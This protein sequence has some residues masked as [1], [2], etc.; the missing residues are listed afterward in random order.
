MVRIRTIVLAMLAVLALPASAADSWFG[1]ELCT[2]GNVVQK[3]GT[4]YYCFST[5]VD[6]DVL[7][8]N[9]HNFTVY[10]N[11][12]H[13][14]TLTGAQ[15]TVWRCDSHP[16]DETHAERQKVCTPWYIDFT[17]DGVPDATPL[18]ATVGKTGWD[19][20]YVGAQLIFIQVNAITA[21]NIARVRVDSHK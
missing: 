9:N 11:P 7:T 14:G 16:T 21:G 19:T 20:P 3:G 15:V 1:N 10:L 5:A 13:D 18:D 8:L 17:G 4:A 2:A 12:D 6:S